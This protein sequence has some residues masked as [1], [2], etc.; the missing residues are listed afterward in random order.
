MIDPHAS[1][2]R[3]TFADLIE[4]KYLSLEQSPDALASSE[5]SPSAKQWQGFIATML[6][7]FGAMA[8]AFSVIFFI[9]ANWQDIGRMTKF[10]LVEIALVM[11]MV[12]FVKCK[13]DNKLK[14]ASLVVSMLLVGA[15]MALFGQ[16]YQ[17]GADP[18][19]L[20]FNWAIVTTPWV[21]ISRSSVMWV[22]W[23]QLLNL[24]VGLY[25]QTFGGFLSYNWPLFLFNALALLV[26]Q[27]SVVKYSFLN[28]GWAINWLALVSSYFG[29]WVFS[30]ALFDDRPIQVLI[31][32]GWAGALFYIY[33]YRTLNV[34]MLAVWS[35]S[36]LVA[37]NALLIKILPDSFDAFSF[38]ILTSVTVAGG[39]YLT[40][41]LKGL[42]KVSRL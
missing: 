5:I 16:T 3:R 8:L 13:H 36:I 22:L 41:W 12:S 27:V 24:S 25:Y 28:K 31:W 39:T 2:T 42:S 10:A 38:L 19:Q 33:R 26:W 32:C 4:Q 7:W 18:W 35:L 40:V 23:L 29:L 6:L 15:L 34:F 1:E 9:A 21:I 30:Q 17:T 11:A 37:G 20:F 14:Q